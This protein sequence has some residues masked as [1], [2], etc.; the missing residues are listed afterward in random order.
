MEL[1]DPFFLF[2]DFLGTSSG[3][4]AFWD[5]GKTESTG[6]EREDYAMLDSYSFGRDCGICDYG[7][8]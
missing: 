5:Q 8:E 2:N 7:F 1:V 4:E 6:L 3:I